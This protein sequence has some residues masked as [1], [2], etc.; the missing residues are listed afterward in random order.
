MRGLSRV[1][2]GV[3][4]LLTACA[5]TEP[6]V[7][8]PR[9]SEHPAISA[10]VPADTASLIVFWPESGKTAEVTVLLDGM[11]V[12]M[13]EPS[14]WKEFFASPGEHRVAAR[15]KTRPGL[16]EIAVRASGGSRHFLQVSPWS[17]PNVAVLTW[18]LSPLAL[19][20]LLFPFI[21]ELAIYG[22]VGAADASANQCGGYVV[23]VIDEATARPK[24]EKLRAS[25]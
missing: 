13:L 20:F 5:T 4:V 15:G 12:G 16:C 11:E 25:R 21:N 10:T 6:K 14:A 18:A 3:V 8:G 19:P 23:A 1:L 2:L 9:F 7:T 24:L 17:D 22:I